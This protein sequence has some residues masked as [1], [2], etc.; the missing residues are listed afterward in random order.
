MLASLRLAI[1]DALAP[2]Q[3]RWIVL[4]LVLALLLL[5]ALWLGVGV[6]LADL[7]LIGIGWLDWMLA[8]AGEIGAL[9][10]CWLLYPAMT[11]LVVGFFLN[12]VVAAVER[13][14]YPDLP[15]ARRIG[16]GEA[17]ASV[18]RLMLLAVVINLALLPLYLLFPVINLFV[19]YLLNGYLVGREYFDLVALRRLDGGAARAMW[20]WHRGR[21]VLAG[22]VIVL[23][24]SIPL[25]NLAAPVVA[26][27]FMLHVFEGLR[28]RVAVEIFAVRKGAWL[29]DD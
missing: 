21:L 23:L 15:P 12:A 8:I 28:R 27:A 2:E 19:Y 9:V 22:V 5:A 4:S 29:I 6:L 13:R 1:D 25:L 16:I 3:R 14:H 11:M 26:A 10:L 20:R 17:I 18:V 24:L 7:H